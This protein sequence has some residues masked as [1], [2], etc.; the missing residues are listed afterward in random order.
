M[1]EREAEVPKVIHQI[2]LRGEPPDEGRAWMAGVRHIA[3]RAGWGYELWSW[4][5]LAAELAEFR[6][7]E[8]HCPL[9]QH[10][11]DV[12]RWLILRDHGGLYLDA[13]LELFRLPG[14][15]CGAWIQGVGLR[16]WDVAQVNCAIQAGPPGH[17]YFHDLLALAVDPVVRIGPAVPMADR[18]IAPLGTR[19]WLALGGGNELCQQALGPDVHVWPPERWNWEGRYK[20]YGVHYGC[21]R[22]WGSVRPAER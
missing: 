6:E 19:A 15:L 21:F 17:R 12:A 2:W 18:P 5:R 22:R 10:Q 20:G 14:R 1:D 16:A 3:Q 11:S 8:A 13:D 9:V 7:R 4:A